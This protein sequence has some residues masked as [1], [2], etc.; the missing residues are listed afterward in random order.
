MQSIENKIIARFKIYENIVCLNDG[1]LYQLTHCP[2]KR[3]KVLRK[4]TYH[5]KR[6]SYYID[7]QLV[8]KKRLIKLQIK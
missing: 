7:G 2:K 5:E 3:T 6:K 8:S 4:L 1:L